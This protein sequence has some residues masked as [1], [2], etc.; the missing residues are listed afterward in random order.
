MLYICSGVKP[1]DFA[2]LVPLY[3]NTPDMTIT[4]SM[5]K[6]KKYNFFISDTSINKE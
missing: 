4:K 1:F 3:K 6:P 2:T 5:G